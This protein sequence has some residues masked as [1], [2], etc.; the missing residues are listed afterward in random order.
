MKLRVASTDLPGVMVLEPL[1]HSDERGF[2]LESFNL[3]DFESV[4]GDS[5]N[6]V[7]DNHSRSSFGVL[8]GLHFQTSRPQGKLVRVVHGAI[9]DVAVDVRESSPC[10]GSW[11]AVELSAENHQQIWVPPGFA[12]G[13]LVLSDYAEVLYKTTDFYSPKLERSI[14]WDDPT[15]GITWPDLGLDPILSNKDQ[16]AMSLKDIRLGSF[17]E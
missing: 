6:F 4:T 17:Q 2:F 15:I 16:N 3:R 1:V 12:H 8:R 9:F 13:F 10:F 5:P 11:A 14:R 7:Q